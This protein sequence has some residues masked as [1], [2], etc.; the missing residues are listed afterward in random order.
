MSALA[1]ALAFARG[2]SWQAWAVIAVLLA[3]GL[4]G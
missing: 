4:Y 3:L 2:L 1:A